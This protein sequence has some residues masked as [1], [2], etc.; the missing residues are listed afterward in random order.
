MAQI[1]LVEDD[2][3]IRASLRR[4]LSAR[5]HDVRWCDRGLDAL[6]LVL[7]DEPTMVLLDLGLP[8]VDG[9]DLVKMVRAVSSVPIIVCTARDDEVHIVRALDL[10]ADDFVVKPFSSEQIDARIRAI[11]RRHRGVDGTMVRAGGLVVEFRRRRAVLD[12]VP[13]DLRPRE[14]DLLAYLSERHGEYVGKAELLREIWGMPPGASDKTVDV[15]MGLG[16]LLEVLDRDTYLDFDGSGVADLDGEG[17]ADAG[18]FGPRLAVHDPVVRALVTHAL[19]RFVSDTGI[20]G[21]RLDSLAS[22]RS[23]T[24][25]STRHAIAVV[26]AVRDRHPGLD[27]VAESS[28]LEPTGP[29]AESWGQEDASVSGAVTA[30]LADL[31]AGAAPGDLAARIAAFVGAAVADR[32]VV[33]ARRVVYVAHHDRPGTAATVGATGARAEALDAASLAL[34][35][36][37]EGRRSLAPGAACGPA[38]AT[39]V[40]STLSV[41]GGPRAESV[42]VQC[43]SSALVPFV[44]A[45]ASPAVGAGDVVGRPAVTVPA[46][47]AVTVV[48]GGLAALANL[49]GQPVVLPEPVCV[50]TVHASLGPIEGVGGCWSTLAPRSVA[51]VEVAR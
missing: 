47:G 16:S 26:E 3:D 21:L 10:G 43:P 13:L 2:A 8:D 41:V 5:G 48:R 28:P 38:A 24:R 30:L 20:D 36:L 25:D 32:D 40:G 46:P 19:D 23:A 29:L 44:A 39:P 7:D 17:D 50:T 22:A 49:A 35:T 9:L 27:L 11:A 15:H 37:V 42:G 6:G 14:F 45:A 33:P 1:L 18:P 31:D 12:G 4:S 51:L 34:L